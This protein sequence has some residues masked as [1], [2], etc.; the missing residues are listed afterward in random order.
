MS[1]S[2]QDQL[3]LAFDFVVN[4]KINKSGKVCVSDETSEM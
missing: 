4:G 2:F 3:T 1:S